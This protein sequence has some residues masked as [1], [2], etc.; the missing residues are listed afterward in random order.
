MLHILNE[1]LKAYI[2][3]EIL[4]EQAELCSK[5]RGTWEQILNIHQIIEEARDFNNTLYRYMLYRL[6]QSLREN[7]IGTTMAGLE[8]VPHLISLISNL[9]IKTEKDTSEKIRWNQ[10]SSTVAK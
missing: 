5:G 6:P 7:Q 2:Q 8:R 9:Y 3:P 4:I 10:K 1:R